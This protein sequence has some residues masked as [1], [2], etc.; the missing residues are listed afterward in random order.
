[1]AFHGAAV[2]A[3]GTACMPWGYGVN[4]GAL[5]LTN[6]FVATA[7]VSTKKL[8]YQR[9]WI[10][11]QST[12]D[13]TIDENVRFF[14]YPDFSGTIFATKYRR[15]AEGTG[16]E[17]KVIFESDDDQ[18]G[19]GIN[20][21]LFTIVYTTTMACSAGAMSVSPDPTNRGFI[22]YGINARA[23]CNGN[24]VVTYDIQVWQAATASFPSKVKSQILGGQ[25]FRQLHVLQDSAGVRIY[26]RGGIL[27]NSQTYSLVAKVGCSVSI[28]SSTIALPT[29]LVP[30][31]L[32]NPG[33]SATPFDVKLENCQSG[34]GT[35]GV[36]LTWRFIAVHP[37]DSTMLLNSES[38]AS[39][40][41]NIAL[42]LYFYDQ[43]SVK[44]II[45]HQLPLNTGY[46]L[47]SPSK[48]LRHSAQYVV[49]PEGQADN[50]SIQPGKFSGQAQ[51]FVQ[52][53]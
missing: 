1:V 11:P 36:W 38:G 49:T 42:N 44:K 27:N 7:R 52:Y 13:C 35:P 53:Q 33:G 48:V 25:G 9:T 46:R 23:G 14:I 30:S 3:D 19:F 12:Q 18:T 43:N 45:S 40:A 41:K 17:V 20:E 28:A 39:P 10:P 34:S 22:I 37:T 51:L 16:N 32:N 31:I 47:D 2:A 5:P 4:A 24:Y 15:R 29:Y 21:T 50:N 26:S 8:L 6:S